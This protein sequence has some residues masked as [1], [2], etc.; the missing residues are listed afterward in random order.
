MQLFDQKYKLYLILPIILYLVFAFNI[1]IFPGIK[2]GIDLKGGTLIIVRSAQTIDE[3]RLESLLKTKFNLSEISVTTTSSPTGSGATIEFEENKDLAPIKKELALA[4]SLIDS[5]PAQARIHAMIVINALP[6]FVQGNIP[7]DEKETVDFA[8]SVFDKAKIAF[9]LE[10]QNSIQQELGLGAD[11]KFQLREIGASLGETFWQNAIVVT[12]AA[13]ILITIIVLIFF[14]EIVP[15]FAIIAAAIFDIMCALGLMSWFGVSLSLATIPALLMLVGFSI[16]TDIMLTTRL[17]KRKENTPADRT[18]EAFKTGLT[19]T[20]TAIASV[21]VL[22]IASYFY[23]MVVVF[24]ISSVL[25]FGLIGDVIS[26]WL[27]NAPVLLIY[28]ERKKAAANS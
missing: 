15:S 23:Q 3:A 22:L 21:S 1:L 28:L 13:M 14:R 20:G 17:L 7:T 6:K 8:S 18:R 5:N 19:M 27:M 25:L 2:Q 26:T 4:Q 24:Q 12:L 10:L 9:E 11:S 16:D